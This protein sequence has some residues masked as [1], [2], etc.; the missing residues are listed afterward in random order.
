MSQQ[1]GDK[2]TATDSF[3]ISEFSIFC[4]YITP[5]LAKTKNIW[6]SSGPEKPTYNSVGKLSLNNISYQFVISNQMYLVF[7]MT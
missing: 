6:F 4:G 2:H 3:L 5:R 7:C 1:V